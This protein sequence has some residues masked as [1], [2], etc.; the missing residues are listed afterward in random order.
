MI[1]NEPD[2]VIFDLDGVLVDSRH[3]FAASVNAALVGLG[4][5][6]RPPESLWQY[7]GPP[8]HETF[9]ELL[10]N[11]GPVVD[12]A[13]EA[14]RRRYRRMAATESKPFDGIPEAL[15]FL[16]RRLPLLVATSKPQ[17]IAGQLLEDLDLRHYFRAVIGPSL[18]ARDEPKS[19]TLARAL[20][21]LPEG[22]E[23]PV[24]IG[25]R[26]FDVYAAHAHDVACIGALWGIGGEDELL[27]AKVDVLVEKPGD[28]IDL[29]APRAV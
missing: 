10:G 1:E 27:A 21:L 18:T 25:D 14:Y 9:A 11:R 17:E 7:L 24:M 16:E 23:T 20:D 3:A 26:Y 28:L 5:Q 8:T 22:C 2:A 19:E 4:R 6:P 13:V 15:E 12:E 29:L